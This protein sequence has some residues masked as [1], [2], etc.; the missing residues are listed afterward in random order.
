M[1]SERSDVRQGWWSVPNL[2]WQC[3]RC[4]D[5]TSAGSRSSLGDPEVPVSHFVS[6]TRPPPPPSAP[7]TCAV[8][9]RSRGSPADFPRAPCCAAE[10]AMIPEPE[11]AV[12]KSTKVRYHP[13]QLFVKWRRSLTVCDSCTDART[14]GLCSWRAEG[15]TGGQ[16]AR[17][18]AQPGV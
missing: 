9:S 17:S 11:K 6:V 15:R 13:R 2:L 1:V 10:V 5:H 4:H 12:D 8:C 14:R 18:A 7:G 3:S 16:G